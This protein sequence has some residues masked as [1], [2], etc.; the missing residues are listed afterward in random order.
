MTT[1][2]TELEDRTRRLVGIGVGILTAATFAVLG[3]VV[4]ESIFYGV[5]MASFSGGGSVLAVP[6]RLRLSAAQASADERVSFSE[7]VA[8]AGGNAQ[9]GLF[10]V[11]LVL[12]AAAMFTLA[13]GGTNPSPTLGITVGISSAVLVAYIGAVIL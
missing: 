4:L 2:G 3:V 12:G 11:G 10:G 1:N 7:T 8:R 6:W 9:Q 13:L 5:L